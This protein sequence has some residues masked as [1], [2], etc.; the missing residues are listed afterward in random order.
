MKSVKGGEAWRVGHLFYGEGGAEPPLRAQHFC[1]HLSDLVAQPGV[2]FLTEKREG[3]LRWSDFEQAH[4]PF[5][6]VGQKSKISDEFHGFFDFF[7]KSI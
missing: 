2:Q 6:G 5:G 4:F 7:L 1:H 3:R